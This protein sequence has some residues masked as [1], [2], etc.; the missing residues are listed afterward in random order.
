MLKRGYP[1]IERP[2]MSKDRPTYVRDF[3]VSARLH[4]LRTRRVG[5]NQVRTTILRH[6]DQDVREQLLVGR[7]GGAGALLKH[8]RK[9]YA[10]VGLLRP[11]A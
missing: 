8:M 6:T 1:C 3:E 9:M 4:N 10:G 7:K 5:W 11:Y 2:R